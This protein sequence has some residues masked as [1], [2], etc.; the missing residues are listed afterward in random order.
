[1]AKAKNPLY[2]WAIDT[3]VIIAHLNGQEPMSARSSY[4]IGRA[5]AGEGI[6]IVSSLAIVEVYKPPRKMGRTGYRDH[7]SI[8]AFFQK[9]CVLIVEL[10]RT[11]ARLAREL[12]EE[13]L[14]SWDSVH[15]ATA[16]RAQ[17]TTLFTLDGDDLTRRS[18]IRNLE[19][20]NPYSI[21]IPSAPSSARTEQGTLQFDLDPPMAADRT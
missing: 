3:S 7:D 15:V 8:E 5:E 21:P 12:C 6:L 10:D 4:L 14:P 20:R 9:R 2:R 1:M 19:L 13:G 16:L 11:I 17:A 18:P